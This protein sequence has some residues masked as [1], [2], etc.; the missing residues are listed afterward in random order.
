MASGGDRYERQPIRVIRV[1][2]VLNGAVGRGRAPVLAVW[3]RGAEGRTNASLSV[4]GS[5]SIEWRGWGSQQCA[6]TGFGAG[7]HFL[8][9]G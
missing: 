7:S 6:T 1:I 9:V 5:E 8:Q 2:I 4:M 3:R